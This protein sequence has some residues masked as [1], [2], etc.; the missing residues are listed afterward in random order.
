MEGF[1]L[2]FIGVYRRV[3]ENVSAFQH[4][5]IGDGW[6]DVPPG[7]S[8]TLYLRYAMRWIDSASAYPSRIA[9]LC[10]IVFTYIITSI[11]PSHGC[12][13]NQCMQCHHFNYTN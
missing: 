5:H 7:S 2:V 11:R 1:G 4:R 10:E 3:L 8:E 12:T 6:V 9:R 13:Q